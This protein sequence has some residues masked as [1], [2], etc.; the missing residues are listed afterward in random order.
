M[1]RRVLIVLAA[2]A[3][4]VPATLAAQDA[5]YAQKR[6]QL[7]KELEDAQK[8]V[9]ELRGQRLQLAA[10]IDNVLAQ[11]TEQRAQQ[12]MLSNEQTSLRQMDSLLTAAQDNLGDQRDRLATLASAIR[13][14]SGAV[15]VVLF[16]ADSSTTQ[17]AVQT[18]TLTVDGTSAATRSYTET[19]RG[20][21]RL[22]AVDEVFRSTVLPTGHSVVLTATVNGQ[23]IS[24]TVNVNAAS[25][26]V[27][28][29]QFALRN[30]QLVQ[31]TWSSKGTTP[32]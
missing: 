14:R 10:R 32:F 2:I 8:M 22:G 11:V 20:A 3:M 17:D 21:L 19:A 16:R 23:S 30:G 18:A 5:T 24:Q 4:A 7:V 6:Q 27:T 31:T 1:T 29:V 12:L 15:L 9:Q 28:Y 13:D 25:A 26:A